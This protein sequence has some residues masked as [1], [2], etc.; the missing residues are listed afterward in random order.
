MTDSLA[1][2]LMHFHVQIWHFHFN[3]VAEWAAWRRW[4]CSWD[5]WLFISQIMKLYSENE[6]AFTFFHL[7]YGADLLSYLMSGQTY[8]LMP[9]ASCPPACEYFPSGCLNGATLLETSAQIQNRHSSIEELKQH[10]EVYIYIFLRLS[11][12]H[13]GMLET[14]SYEPSFRHTCNYI[15]AEDADF[16]CKCVESTHHKNAQSLFKIS[17]ARERLAS[18]WHNNCNIIIIKYNC[19]FLILAFK[20]NNNNDNNNN[21]NN[22]NNKHYILAMGGYLQGALHNDKQSLEGN[23]LWLLKQNYKLH[24]MATKLIMPFS[25]GLYQWPQVCLGANIWEYWQF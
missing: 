13:L 4:K 25:N 20:A 3:E 24:L 17:P 2:L 22:N 21:I 16:L 23:H 9:M 10:M 5:D 12:V 18:P 6:K 19:H 11:F 15:Y 1:F 14:R 7:N 8:V